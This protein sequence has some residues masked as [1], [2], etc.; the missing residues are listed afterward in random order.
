MRA[1]ELP[2]IP[3]SAGRAAVALVVTGLISA[4]LVGVTPVAAAAPPADVQ[5][6]GLS[7]R[8]VELIWSA[9]TNADTYA[10]LRDGNQIATTNRTLFDDTALSA[11]TSYSYQVAAIENGIASSPSAPVSTTTQAPLDSIA[12]SSV[13]AITVKSTTSTSVSLSWGGATD[14]Q[15]IEGYRIF[16]GPAGANP[17]SLIDISTTDAVASYTDS[18]LRSG[19]TYTYGVQAIDTE[20]NAGP[21]R[22]IQATTKSASD[23]T[24]P[25]APSTA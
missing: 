18:Y 21:M 19:T 25:A 12:P 11:S 1:Q 15:R 4:S 8:T 14:N 7:D 6:Q 10:V 3:L 2:T 16:R 13:G 5:A 20:D 9:V 23:S 17:S 22:T 24:S